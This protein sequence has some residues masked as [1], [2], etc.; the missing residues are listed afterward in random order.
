MLIVDH[1]DSKSNDMSDTRICKF[2]KSRKI[3]CVMFHFIPLL[4]DYHVTLHA[5]ANPTGYIIAQLP[6]NTW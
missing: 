5:V 4:L 3:L 1:V 6:R 2:E